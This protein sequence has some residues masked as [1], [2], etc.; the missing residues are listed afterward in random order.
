[1]GLNCLITR[2]NNSRLIGCCCCKAKQP[3]FIAR[4]RKTAPD[5][6]RTCSLFASW[7]EAPNRPTGRPPTEHSIQASTLVRLI[8]T[9]SRLWASWG[10]MSFSR[11]RLCFL[12]PGRIFISFTELLLSHSSHTTR[13]M[14][15]GLGGCCATLLCHWQSAW[16]PF[17]NSR[18]LLYFVWIN[19]MPHAGGCFCFWNVCRRFRFM[20]G[21]DETYSCKEDGL[22]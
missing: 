14:L 15:T 7:M 17:R 20:Q 21:V 6:R 1:M 2:R 19:W 8:R 10:I 13:Q 12:L 16:T 9:L 4:A 5:I 11:L 22:I 3:Q 18:C